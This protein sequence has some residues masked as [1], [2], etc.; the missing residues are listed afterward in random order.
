MMTNGTNTLFLN[1]FKCVPYPYLLFVLVMCVHVPQT[2]SML[3][4]VL[5][6]HSPNPLDILLNG[7]YSIIKNQR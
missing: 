6:T 2:G 5:Y 3:S 4:L 7:Q 1:F